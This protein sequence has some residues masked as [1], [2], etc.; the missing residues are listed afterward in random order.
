MIVR[1]LWKKKSTID[2]LE[3]CKG[4]IRYYEIMVEVMDFAQP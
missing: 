1:I 4:L 2:R 3:A